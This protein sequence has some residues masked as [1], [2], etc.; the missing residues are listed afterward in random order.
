[1]GNQQSSRVSGL[2]SQPFTPTAGAPTAGHASSITNVPGAQTSYD[3]GGEIQ[4]QFGDAG[5]IT[6]SYGP[7]DNFSADRQRV[8]DALMQR[9]NPQLQI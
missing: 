2:L 9:M 5:N 1:M 4:S 8:E 3:P 6:N 7:A